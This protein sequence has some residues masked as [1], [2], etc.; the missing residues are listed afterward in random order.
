MRDAARQIWLLTST[1][2][3]ASPGRAAICLLEMVGTVVTV[4]NPV[5]LKLLVD[6]AVARDRGS[7]V[8][9]VVALMASA[10]VAFA[11]TLAG[12]HARIGLAERAGFE[13]DRQ[14]AE[15]TSRIPS[16]EHQERADY[17]DQLEVVREQRSAL[18]NSL[19]FML[20]LARS[21]VFSVATIVVAATIEPRLLLLLLA[22]LPALVGTRFRY[23]WKS[24][25]EDA[26]A[27]RWRLTRHLGELVTNASAGMELRIFHLGSEI[28]ARLR[29]SVAAARSPYL[30]AERKSALLS[31]AETVFFL[32]AAGLVI[33]WLIV[34]TTPGTVVLAIAMLAGLQTAAVQSAWMAAHAADS[35]R[36][37][38]RLLW[39]RSYASSV[40]R[41]QYA[42]TASPP[43]ALR[44]GISLERVS[45]R[46]H[47]AS[48]PSLREV[49]L[50]L[51]AGS[52][53]ALVGEN[54]AGK[55]TL[56]KLLTGLYRPTGGR[57][58][59]DGVDLASLDVEAWRARGS[60]A[61]QDYAKFEFL[62]QQSVGVGF[63]PSVD[64]ASAVRTA[65]ERAA[66]EELERSLPSGLGT[67]L[68]PTWE[69]GVDLSGG[70]WQK[71]ALARALMREEPL[72]LVFD[73][74]TSAL[75]APTEHALFERYAA[76]ARAGRSRGAITL[77]VTHRFSTVRVA[78]LILVL[79]EGEVA[80]YGTHEELMETQGH[81]AAL[82][83]LQATGY[84]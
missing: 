43:S 64:D 19:R 50:S 10:G 78:D 54:G 17:L 26:A 30:V 74:P 24:A 9:A 63:L 37:A 20:V 6:G 75:D 39:L 33:G 16:L 79:S 82:Y 5:W 38:G 70:Q 55:S 77:L 57:I 76:A 41:S 62:T 2:V 83:N 15:L 61:F 18:G 73:E 12:N 11:L 14:V 21:L 68:G 7:I 8:L 13:F 84:R 34:D 4:L 53:V 56:V 52:V 1:A 49:S 42:G 44:S 58:L 80:E 32:L 45:F 3:R 40:A 35:L 71:V 31:F 59:V 72:L 67:Q 47:G 36:T 23:R 28:R 60:A 69:G 27:P 48:A 51:P 22:G 66:A 65:L 25:A 29:R 81:Y 46:Y